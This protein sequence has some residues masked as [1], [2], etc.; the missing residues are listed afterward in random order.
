MFPQGLKPAFLLALDGVAEATALQSIIFETSSRHNCRKCGLMVKSNT[1][2]IGDDLIMA[3]RS[4]R[5]RRIE[6]GG[7][8][9]RVFIRSTRKENT[10]PT[11]EVSM[12]EGRTVDQ[13][14]QMAKAVT[15]A[16]C[17]TLSVP[18]EAVT[19]I[20]REMAKANSPK[21]AS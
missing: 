16:I 21:Q 20:I 13:K 2:L 8:A 17:T 6:P 12:F 7:L 15:S 19:I 10:M 14:R 3:S 4:A 11:V 1:A 18:E 5:E 9:G